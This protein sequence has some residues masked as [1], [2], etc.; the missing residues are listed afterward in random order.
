MPKDQSPPQREHKPLSRLFAHI[1]DK[2]QRESLVA[3]Y[4]GLKKLLDESLRK[5]LN[6]LIN[7]SRI[8]TDSEEIYQ[9][10][11]MIALLADQ[12]GYRRA[13]VK[14]LNILP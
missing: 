10:P 7:E 8:K 14:V 6:R 4:S 3:A 13:L 12:Q 11:N 9:T 1:K 5:E 2:E